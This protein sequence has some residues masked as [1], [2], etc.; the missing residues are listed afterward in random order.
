MIELLIF[1]SMLSCLIKQ[2]KAKQS[3]SAFC[4]MLRRS[5]W[6]FVPCKY[7]HVAVLLAALPMQLVEQGPKGIFGSKNIRSWSSAF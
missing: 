1:T 6:Y 5:G 7:D 3:A 2:K 4:S